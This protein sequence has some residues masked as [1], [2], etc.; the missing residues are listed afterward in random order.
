LNLEIWN[1]INGKNI[2]NNILNKIN[3]I[4]HI[5]FLIIYQ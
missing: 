5:V 2:L 4:D 1:K 3:N